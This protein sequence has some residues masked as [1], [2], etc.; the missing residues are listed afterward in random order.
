[1]TLFVERRRPA[2]TPDLLLRVALAFAMI[3]AL[4]V[5]TNL[6]AIRAH[7]FPD[8]DDVLRLVQVRDLI[9]GQ[10]WFDVVQH[11]SGD[12]PMHWSRL[13]DLPVAAVILALRGVVGT[14]T[15]EAVALIVVPLLT[16]LV[17]LFLIG[18]I[19]WR[20]LGDEMAM[21][22]CLT[23]AFS[24]PVLEQLR[25]MRIDHHGWQIA[26]VLLALNGLMARSPRIGGWMIGGALATALNIS[27]EQLPM[28]VAFMGVLAWRW[29][30]DR[31]ERVWL[32]NALQALAAVSAAL[33]VATH[34]MTGTGEVCDAIAPVHLSVFAWSALVVTLCS[35][36]EPRPR[37]F[38]F[39]GLALAAVGSLALV[40]EM[41]PACTR[42][43]FVALDPIVQSLWLDRISEGLPI[44]RQSL[45]VM[46]QIAIPPVLA[47][48]AAVKLAGQSSGWLRRW[49]IDYTVLLATAF[50]LSLFVA[51]ADA[52]AGALATL[53]LG[54]QLRTWLRVV[55]D[56]KRPFHRAMVYSGISVA[57]VPAA[58]A[59][60]LVSAA[61]GQAQFAAATRVADP[62][63]ICTISTQPATLGALS[64]GKVL[65]PLDQSSLILLDTRHD[66]VATGHHR[67]PQMA[68]VIRAFI[69]PDAAARAIIERE[70]VNYVAMCPT[71]N[72]PLNYAHEAPD[73]LAAHL[74]AGQVP[75]W[76]EP[77]PSRGDGWKVWRVRH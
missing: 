59:L 22:A 18:R 54:W 25:P 51:R 64:P 43:A 44:W 28:T 19:A 39:G 40:F 35:A 63:K 20:L 73:G 17:C 53:P 60:L 46:L 58:P 11:R 26:L 2:L 50:V 15:A 56:R 31:G 49:W 68:S 45:P 66:V 5:V 32:V 1:V 23:F 57:L 9:G 76:L 38:V 70:K 61:P 14:A 7:R 30:A 41:A 12:T 74:V 72:E 16:L 48:I 8:P 6:A 37:S 47:L 34:G 21:F 33:F 36:A 77:V 27:I 4:L 69:A 10:G 75:A 42:G 55:R 13:V 67:A 3:A 71:T 29:G 52:V 65:A 24:V 62:T